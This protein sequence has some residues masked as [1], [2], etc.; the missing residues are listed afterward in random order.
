MVITGN[1][2]LSD[3]SIEELFQMKD[4]IVRAAREEGE[5]NN[6]LRKRF[7]DISRELN[8]RLYGERK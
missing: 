5:I 8:S 7:T 2:K 1:E 4:S 3:M 6:T